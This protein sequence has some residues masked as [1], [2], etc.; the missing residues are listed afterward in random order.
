[1]VSCPALVT[2]FMSSSKLI[3]K[4]CTTHDEVVTVFF[5]ESGIGCDIFLLSCFTHIPCPAQLLIGGKER[6]VGL[7]VKLNTLNTGLLNDA[8]RG[9]RE[10]GL[11]DELCTHAVLVSISIHTQRGITRLLLLRASNQQHTV[12]C[13]M[14]ISK[15]APRLYNNKKYEHYRVGSFTEALKDENHQGLS[16]CTPNITAEY[17]PNKY[18]IILYA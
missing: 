12:L 9:Q 5:A 4:N 11:G 3:I 8:E 14:Y 10:G 6:Q 18:L 7:Q 2:P 17:I 13:K 1:M 15:P 16:M